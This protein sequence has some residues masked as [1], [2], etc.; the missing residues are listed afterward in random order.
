[1]EILTAILCTVVLF[2]FYYYLKWNY[3]YW[4]RI[5]LDCLEP[6]YIFGNTISLCKGVSTS[7][8]FVKLY[9]EMKSKGYKHAGC[10]FFLKP[11]YMPVDL[12]FV[13]N[14]IQTDYEYFLNHGIY[15]DEESEPIT[16]HLFSLEN[17]KWRTLRKKL[18]PTF[19]S[20]KIKMMYPT[21]FASSSGLKELLEQHAESADAV[22]IKKVLLR[23]SIDVIVSVAFGLNCNSL[24]EKDSKF[25]E[26][27]VKM[28]DS[29]PLW[30]RCKEAAIFLFPK[31]LLKAISFKFMHK[32]VEDFFFNLVGDTIKYREENNVYRKDFMHLLLQL[33]NRGRVADDAFI[34]RQETDKGEDFI[35]FNELVAQCFV[36]FVAGFETSATTLSFALLQLALN[37]DVQDKLRDEIL[38]IKEKYDGDLCYDAILEMTYLEKVVYE[39]LRK[40]PP[41]PLLPRVCN[42]DYKVPNTEVIIR[43]GTRVV[44][45]VIA[46]QNDPD[47][48]PDPEKFD[49]ERFSEENKANRPSVA[50]LPFG[51]GPRYCI[52]SRFGLLE[53]KVALAVILSNFNI[54]LDSKTKIPIQY[55]YT[56]GFVLEVDGGIWLKIS[57]LI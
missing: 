25:V 57:K 28:F 17:E 30:E 42:K 12:Q 9:K 8:T 36:F 37:K 38:T 14:V 40:H 51:E 54:E 33:K 35:T 50:Y 13:K 27:A 46:I 55:A 34:T 20:G 4:N 56:N 43:E 47:I 18:S 26:I 15:H 23:F 3:S 53:V 52:G 6:H 7:E 44:I 16:A 29:V 22:N 24:K 48:Y 21:L 39:T 2:S 5:G 31:K 19:T 49:P 1:M 45:P 41:A 32:D 10:Y 11:F